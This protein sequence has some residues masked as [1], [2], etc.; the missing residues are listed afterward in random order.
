LKKTPVK[1]LGLEFFSGSAEEAVAEILSG[2]LLVA[3][4]APGLA[5][6]FVKDPYYRKALQNSRL[7]IP[8]SGL[9]VLL[10]NR[11]S[12]AKTQLIKRLSGL[13][14]LKE[15]L[16]NPEV[17]KLLQ[18]SFWIMPNNEEAELNRRWLIEKTGTELNPEYI[19]IAPHYPDTGTVEDLRLLS[20]LKATNPSI[21]FINVGG[22]TQERLGD[23]IQENLA[24]T[25]SILCC[26]AAIAFLAGG[27]TP[28]PDWADRLKIGWFLRCL[29]KPSS[30]VPRYWNARTLI[31]LMLKYREH[32]PPIE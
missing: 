28:I 3:P 2:G 12:S 6:N 24:T 30:Y 5:N 15:F 10:W 14:F 13:E 21:I 32:L 9:M 20:Q 16:T 23:Y 19:Y 31:P 4:A 8:D 11:I 18:S 29:S 27:Q 1:I 7:C 17:R 22:G 26:G 25:P